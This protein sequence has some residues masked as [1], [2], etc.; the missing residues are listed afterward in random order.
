[1]RKL[2]FILAL[3]LTTTMFMFSMK[4][5]DLKKVKGSTVIVQYKYYDKSVKGKLRDLYLNS[6]YLVSLTL[7]LEN[8][9]LVLMLNEDIS[10][11]Q[12]V[13]EN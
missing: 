5:G 4:H 3:L 1:M 9:D 11:I 8:G 13:K 2:L 10:S 7:E 12:I 6:G